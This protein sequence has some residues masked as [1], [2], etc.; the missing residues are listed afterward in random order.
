ASVQA[1]AFELG[2]TPVLE[3]PR[4]AHALPAPPPGLD[5]I[6][7]RGQSWRIETERGAVHVWIPADYDPA[8]A[9]TV[10]FVHGYWT[11]CDA[12]WAD[13][14]LPEQFALSGVNAMFIVPEAPQNK[15][16]KVEW[17]SLDA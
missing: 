6:A 12:A 9:A 5:E 3:P 16:T 1:R 14:R 10:V 4:I 7:A 17:P 2:T 15:R 8:T 13:Y 11:D